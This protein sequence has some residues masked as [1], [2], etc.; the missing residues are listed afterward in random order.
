MYESRHILL[1]VN[2]TTFTFIP[3]L[4]PTSVFE[5]NEI[6]FQSHMPENKC[7]ELINMKQENKKCKKQER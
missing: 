4:Y 5:D 6:K 2:C 1:I 3:N 7:F